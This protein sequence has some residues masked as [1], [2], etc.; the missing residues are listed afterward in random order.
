MCYPYSDISSKLY[1][2]VES[3][4]INGETGQVN[5]FYIFSVTNEHYSVFLAQ[6]IS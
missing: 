1:L 6:L 5:D 2:L 3:T 4:T